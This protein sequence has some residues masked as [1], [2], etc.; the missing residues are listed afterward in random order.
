MKIRKF[1]SVA[2]AA[3][4][5]ASTVAVTASADF[6]AIEG[7][8][9]CL[10][11]DGG[12][13]Y[14]ICLL[15]DGTNNDGIPAMS[16]GIDLNKVA[17]V[18][19]TFQVVDNADERDFWDGEIGGAIVISAHSDKTAEDQELYNKYNWVTAGQ[20][21]GVEDEALDINTVDPAQSFVTTKVGDYQYKV[22]G[23]VTNPFTDG[24]IG[25]LSLY[26]VFMQVWNCPTQVEVVQT[27]M[28]DAEGNVLATF[29]A[30]GTPNIL[31]PAADAPAAPDAP[32]DTSAPA[33]VVAADDKQSPD[34]GV[35][36]VAAVAG[37]AVVAAG[38]VVLAKKRK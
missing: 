27:E 23:D 35:E 25:N 21:W 13:N 30:M 19:F 36:G 34:T 20:F 3:A 22:E 7:G 4:V 32:A 17:H 15:S 26:R 8:A 11:A 37:L 5:V 33:G 29:D 1:L 38:A 24:D 6:S 18:A 10:L 14:G 16:V 9:E 12:G 28:S 2:A 31:V